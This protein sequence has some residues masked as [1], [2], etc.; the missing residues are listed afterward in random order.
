MSR[1]RRKDVT[2]H[3]GPD[4]L[5]VSIV[6][7]V[8]FNADSLPEL[9][10][11]L[12]VATLV[13]REAARI[14]FEYV[15]VDDGS[16]DSSFDVL[17]QFQEDRNDITVIRLARNFGGVNAIKVGL[18]HA[19]GR[20]AIIMAADLQDPPELLPPMVAAWLDGAR[21]VICERISR[22]DARGV[23]WSSGLYHALIRKLIVK[24]YPKG[25]FDMFLVDQI[26]IKY[27]QL[28]S[29]SMYP[30]IL[31]F[32]LGFE[33]FVI[34]FERPARPYGR[35]RWSTK[36]R[37]EAFAN[38][39][40]GYSAVPIQI[41]TGIGA[42]VALLSVLYAI[43]L[44]TIKLTIGGVTPGYSALVIIVSLLSGLILLT[45]GV[46]GNYVWRIYEQVS[47]RPDAVI[48]VVHAPDKSRIHSA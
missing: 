17:R 41:V 10:A 15:F 5:I 26:M 23:R 27:L 25:G 8:Y 38:V 42:T 47:G 29:K 9:L 21:F 28:D 16:G 45:L 12:D 14:E 20:A 48:D 11:R 1:P 13:C 46:I 24:T 31:A 34:K 43:L 33:P 3:V 19:N 36:K 39:I 44:I 2:S 6:I 22:L 37:M 4:P 7:P 18:R 35:S 30:Q 32:W 40:F